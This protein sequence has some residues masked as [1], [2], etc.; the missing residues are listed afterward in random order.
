MKNIDKYD[1]RTA[2]VAYDGEMTER[3][4]HGI[5]GL[6]FEDWV[7]EDVDT[8]A[9]LI[10]EKKRE[11]EAAKKAVEEEKEAIRKG[12]E[13]LKEFY[14]ANG[15]EEADKLS[16]EIYR[17]APEYDLY[18]KH[19]SACNCFHSGMWEVYCGD[20]DGVWDFYT[21]CKNKNDCF[22]S[23]WNNPV[24]WKEQMKGLVQYIKPFVDE[25][26]PLLEKLKAEGGAK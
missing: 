6:P 20:F 10:A 16:T 12:M 1:L 11:E 2:L 7:E 8:T 4:K 9:K 19:N 5:E 25:A 15:F 14:K 18:M 23:N 17:I 24:E 22:S 21:Y 13:E 26:K 3:S